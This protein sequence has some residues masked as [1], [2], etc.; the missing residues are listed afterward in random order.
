MK[1]YVPG[2]IL[3][4]F[5]FACKETI[6]CP[7]DDTIPQV[8][9]ISPKENAILVDTTT[10]LV[11]ASDDKGVVK[12]EIYINNQT[13]WDR[14]FYVEPYRYFWKIPQYEDTSRYRIYAKAYDG[15]DNVSSSNVVNV[16]VYR[17]QPPSNLQI[18]SEDAKS[19]TLTWQDN[20]IGEDE[21]WVEKSEDYGP[22]VLVAKVPADTTHFTD[23]SL[24]TNSVYAYRIKAVKNQEETS[25]SKYI[26]AKYKLVLTPLKNKKIYNFSLPKKQIPFLI[27]HIAIVYGWDANL[28]G[29]DYRKNETIFL[30]GASNEP[31]YT[32][33]AY[34]KYRDYFVTA[35]SGGSFVLY[36]F[37][38]G[39][40]F[41][42]YHKQAEITSLTDVEFARNHDYIYTLSSRGI[43][44]KWGSDD[45]IF[46]KSYDV[47]PGNSNSISIRADDLQLITAGADST[48]NAW[49]ATTGDDIYRIVDE[50]GEITKAAYSRDGKYIFSINANEP[51]IKVW[52]ATNAKYIRSLFGHNGKVTIFDQDYEGRYLISG[53][54]YG[55]ITV[56]SLKDFSILEYNVG[57]H[58][59]YI[60]GLSIFSHLSDPKIINVGSA[61]SDGKIQA[62][63]L[64]EKWVKA[65]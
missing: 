44:K 24:N 13:S 65:R 16:T 61:S 50:G 23:E 10:I 48:I 32:A 27:N 28:S 51:V 64:R 52:D 43:V 6:Q 40:P 57:V 2:F 3:L 7:V 35:K 5:I 4:L 17:F 59:E 39:S 19:L 12:V 47:T 56:W 41:Y 33:L 20:S 26:Y 25:Y 49:D 55:R 34:D 62:W 38:N 14:I 60:I 53:D 58:Q 54:E 37:G 30:W 42:V 18:K 8:K 63:D 29:W 45:G 22:F 31:Y 1:Y 11:E 9:I 21:F 36:R 15:D 46:Y